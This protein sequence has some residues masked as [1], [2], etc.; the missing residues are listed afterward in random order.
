MEHKEF[1]DE[2]HRFSLKN[3]ELS[4][5]SDY[6]KDKKEC[7][8]CNKT[9]HKKGEQMYCYHC[10][11]PFVW[12]TRE[13]ISFGINEYKQEP[14]DKNFSSFYINI[15]REN[16]LDFDIPRDINMLKRIY[17]SLLYIQDKILL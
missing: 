9:I 4:L 15:N 1:S 6:Q 7:P 11:T 3:L 14:C 10:F 2:P 17:K 8:K 12:D 5:I 16:P 13:I